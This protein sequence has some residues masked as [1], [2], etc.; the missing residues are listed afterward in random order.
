MALQKGKSNLL[1]SSCGVRMAALACTTTL[2]TVKKQ[3]NIFINISRIASGQ[4]SK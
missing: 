1:F 3:K 2:G 4:N